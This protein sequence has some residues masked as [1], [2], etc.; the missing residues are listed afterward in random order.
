MAHSNGGIARYT[1]GFNAPES[2]VTHVL[3][4]DGICIL[5]NALSK[6]ETAALK[7][8]LYTLAAKTPAWVR[9]HPAAE[10]FTLSMSPLVAARQRGNKQIAQII[11]AF[12]HP[13]LAKLCR[14]L[15]GP[16]WYFDRIIVELKPPSQEPITDWHADQF[17]GRGRC[18][19]C[20]I[21]TGDTNADSGAF[22]FVPGSHHLMQTIQKHNRHDVADL[23]YIETIRKLAED[24][25]KADPTSGTMVRAQLD[26]MQRHI[27]SALKSDD[28]YSV[29]G[30]AG[31]AVLFDAT[32]IHRG[33][34]PRARERL[35]VRSHSRNFQLNQV[36]ASRNN[37]VS[38]AQRLYLRAN[39]A[40]HE[41]LV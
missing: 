33:G 28:H 40:R 3:A 32:G 18:I 13:L 7:E 11:N 2:E 1:S 23:R 19:K 29:S 24:V 14:Q 37:F 38:T 4:E 27:D 10:G 22:S 9:N 6:Q 30:P 5:E 20:M 21:Y 26:E 35:I 8:E 34:V 31:S 12:G 25:I 15:L 16:L 41:A 17:A 36:L 39:P